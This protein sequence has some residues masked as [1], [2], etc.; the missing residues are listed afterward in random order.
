MEKRI[1]RIKDFF[2]SLQIDDGLYQIIIQ[3]KKDWG[4][5]EDESKKISISK[6]D[7]KQN[8]Y[9]YMGNMDS[10]T[11]DEMFDFI[12][13]TISFN[14]EIDSKKELFKEKYNELLNI[15]A[16]H[17]LDELKTLTYKIKSS[18]KSKNKKQDNINPTNNISEPI[19]IPSDS[20]NNNAEYNEAEVQPNRQKIRRSK[21]VKNVTERTDIEDNDGLLLNDNDLKGNS[22]IINGDDIDRINL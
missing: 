12:E 6:I 16:S 4:I 7:P 17:S 20:E 5:V 19:E 13:K 14:Y 9:C 11:L 22:I 1:E 8:F 3:L 15:F 21:T 10:I 2:K 18:P